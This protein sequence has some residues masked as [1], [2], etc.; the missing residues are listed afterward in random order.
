[1]LS[2]LLRSEVIDLQQDR[3]EDSLRTLLTERLDARS[4][5]PLKPSVQTCTGRM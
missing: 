5:R 3:S 4:V 1:M 2:D